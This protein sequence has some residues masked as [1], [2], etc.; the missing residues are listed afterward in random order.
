MKIKWLIWCACFLCLAFCKSFGQTVLIDGLRQQF[1]GETNTEK[2]LKA[3]ISLCEYHQSIHKDSLYKYALIA[4]NLSAKK[5]HS[6]DKSLAAII[7]IN[8]YLRLGK[9]DSARTITDAEL[10]RYQVKDPAS[11]TVYFKLFALKVDCFGETS[12]F[13]DA[14][15]E[16]YKIISEAEQYKD[17]LVLAKNMSNLGV[18]NYNLDHVPES[19]NWY[20]KGLAYCE[21]APRFY[22]NQAVL[23]IN[24]AEAYRW[25][26]KI[27]SST[28]YIDRAIPL[29]EKAGNLY[30][31]ANALRVKANI[32]KQQKKYELAEQTIMQ[33]I[34]IRQKAEGVLPLSN[35]QL[36]LAGIYM[37]KGSTDKAIQVLTDGLALSSA[38]Q[39]NT[40]QNQ[41]A[42]NEADALKIAYYTTLAKCYELKGDDKNCQATLR[43]IIVAKDALYEANSARAIAEL[44]TKYEFQKKESTI[45]KQKLDITQKNYLFYG[46][47]ILSVF[48]LLLL[49][50]LFKNYSRKQSIKMQLAVAEEK[51]IAT[52]SI[53]DA[54]EQE[55]KR[56]AADLHDN[57]GAYASA[58]RADVE[59]ITG[60]GLAIAAGPLQN[61]QQHSQEIIDSLRDTIWV[62]NKENITI[63]GISDRIKNHINKLRPSYEHIQIQLTESIEQDNRLSSQHALNVFRIIQEAIHNALKHSNASHI[64]IYINSNET[65]VIK[66]MDDGMGMEAG[67]TSNGNGLLNMQ[68][69][70][71]E[72]GMQLSIQSDSRQGTILVL[73]TGTTNLVLKTS[74]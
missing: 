13:K 18:I 33:C 24:I 52:Q 50:L 25:I 47:L 16:L 44:Q 3:I 43:K 58:I 42:A 8:A 56:I 12:N 26:E 4:Q 1:Y 15:S 23:F 61:L 53:I 35:E 22:S 55:R 6:I 72:T 54:E 46:S 30:F 14:I 73:E 37:H 40:K 29:C 10:L 65:I 64:N 59:K 17:S 45:I 62:L 36:A 71:K 21:D 11:R 7:L 39:V 2:K 38:A 51:R 20:F 60:N 74:K 66:V 31:L 19:F 68:A 48:A 28:Y 5:Q 57:I 63:T 49:W 9:I 41:A 69:R 34:D 67:S 70:A 32:Y 27:D